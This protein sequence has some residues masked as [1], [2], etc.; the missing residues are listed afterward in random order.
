MLRNP[1]SYYRI[2][3]DPAHLG[4]EIGFLAML[5]TWG[6]NLMHHP[7]LHSLVP[8]GGIAPDGSRWIACRPG[9]FLPVRV[10]SWL[11]R[12]RFLHLLAYAFAAGK[13]NFFAAHHHLHEPAAFQRYLAPVHKT[14][15]VVYPTRPFA[16]RRQ[17]LH[18]VGR[19]THRVAISN[20]RLL[21]IDDGKVRLR[22]KDYRRD[23]HHAA[24]TRCRRVHPPLPDPCAAGCLPAHPLLRFPRQLS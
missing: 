17:V 13:L 4:T 8:S 24:M 9:F 20:N 3:A 7:H 21:S 19:Y 15:W 1:M 14:E 2:A 6:Q 18:Y 16:G 22:W 10:L 12:G 11:F 5:H 23:N